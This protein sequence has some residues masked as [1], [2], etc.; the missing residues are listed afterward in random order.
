MEAYRKV[1]KIH[2]YLPPGDIL[3]F[4]TGVQEINRLTSLLRKTFPENAE[5]SRCQN[6]RDKSDNTPV[7][8]DK[9]VKLEEYDPYNDEEVDSKIDMLKN[10]RN[11]EGPGDDDV[12]DNDD[13]SSSDEDEDEIQRSKHDMSLPLKA[14]PLYSSLSPDQQQL[15]FTSQS[16]KHR[17]VVVATNVAETSL[18]IPGIVYV[19]DSG[20]V[21]TKDY[22]PLTGMA[23]FNVV[24]TSRAAAA[25]RSGRAGRTCP[26]HC[27]R[28]YSSAVMGMFILH[29]C[30]AALFYYGY[31]CSGN[32]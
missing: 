28:L 23:Q 7:S 18:T 15:V 13:I 5:E 8:A 1:C 22:C 17:L 12:S 10:D 27:Y 26:G 9:K 6:N 19:V 3:V 14:L 29:D 11:I 21:K 25:Q 32:F 31:C 4:L 20:K 24:W 16:D 2:R 30:D